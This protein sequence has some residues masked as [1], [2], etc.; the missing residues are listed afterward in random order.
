MEKALFSHKLASI[1]GNMLEHYDVA[2]FGLL[3]P[4]IAPHFFGEKD[5]IIALIMT[6]ALIPLSL[7]TEPLGSLVFG[8][9][10]DRYG[11]RQALLIS[12]VSTAIITFSLGC[13]PSYKAI[14]AL[15]PLLLALLRM[16]QSF[17]AAGEVVGAAI[18]ALEHTDKTKRS[19]MNGFYDASS[20]IGTLLASFALTVF[21]AKDWVS[22]HWRVLFWLGGIPAL[23]G[24]FLRL[25]SIESSEYTLSKKSDTIFV[26]IMRYKSCILSIIL[27]SGFTYTTYAFAFTLMNGYIPLVTSLTASQVIEIN[28]WLLL[29]DILT[30]PLFGWLADKFGKE[31]IMLTATMTSFFVSIPLFSMMHGADIFFV[32]FVRFSI[33]LIG[34]A[35]AASYYVWAIEQVAPQDRYTIIALSGSIGSQLI[36]APSSAIS[37]WLYHQLQWVGAPGVYLA[38]VALFAF[39]GIKRQSNFKLVSGQNREIA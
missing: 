2:L 19:L 16:M 32:I 26:L 8:R 21:S 24:I 36:G 1:V 22:D 4:F 25:K 20:V 3:A 34:V 12:L 35:F 14:G 31:K 6:Y 28:T 17:C 27:A 23:F 18:F 39:Y 7:I 37:L 15:S 38:L 10:G 33:V 5:P 13:L 29:V 9:I 30:L 11:R